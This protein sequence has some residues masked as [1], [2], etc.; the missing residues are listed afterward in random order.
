M[1]TAS[2]NLGVLLGVP[3]VPDRGEVLI[4]RRYEPLAGQWSLPGAD[5]EVGETLAAA[6]AREMLEETVT[7]GPRSIGRGDV[8]V[9]KIAHAFAAIPAGAALTSGWSIICAG[10]RCARASMPG[11][12]IRSEV[13]AIGPAT[14]RIAGAVRSVTQK[15]LDVSARCN[16]APVG[17]RQTGR[18]ALL[19]NSQL[20]DGD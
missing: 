9:F 2:Q 13:T 17:R 6:V 20:E 10:S 11:Y 7:S 15:A 19:R 4:K 12:E 16:L 5:G 1:I 14:R 18:R 3:D 8:D